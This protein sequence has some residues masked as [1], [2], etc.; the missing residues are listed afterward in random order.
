MPSP[1]GWMILKLGVGK[2]SWRLQGEG[3]GYFCGD[4]LTR[5]E[6]I[7]VASVVAAFAVGLVVKWW[8]D[9][10]SLRSLPPAT[11]STH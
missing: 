8:R 1:G 11:V 7:L 9:S 10:A 4:L 6:Q 3:A 5:R 2:V